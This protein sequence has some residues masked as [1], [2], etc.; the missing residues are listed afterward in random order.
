MQLAIKTVIFGYNGISNQ[1]YPDINY[2]LLDNLYQGKTN[3]LHYKSII[4]LRSI[5]PFFKVFLGIISLIRF[6]I[7]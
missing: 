6:F 5:I 4:L 7:N 3:V 2:L 1:K